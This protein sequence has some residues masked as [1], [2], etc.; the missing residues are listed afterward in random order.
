MTTNQ[1]H[2]GMSCFASFFYEANHIFP[3]PTVCESKNGTSCEECLKNVTVWASSETF[4]RWFSLSVLLCMYKQKFQVGAPPPHLLDWFGEKLICSIPPFLLPSL[5][6]VCFSVSRTLS[7]LFIA[8]VMTKEGLVV[9]AV[10]VVYRHQ[11]V[12]DVS[13]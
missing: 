7:S 13:R 9:L 10:P 12:P 11:V 3:L 4:A 2:P 8:C 6:C 1:I 5:L